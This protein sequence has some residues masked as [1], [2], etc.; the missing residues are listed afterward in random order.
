MLDISD[1]LWEGLFPSFCFSEWQIVF[2]CFLCML[3]CLRN[4]GIDLCFLGPGLVLLR[5]WVPGSQGWGSLYHPATASCVRK[6]LV[7]SVQDSFLLFSK[8]RDDFPFPFLHFLQPQWILYSI[9]RHRICCPLPCGLTLL[10]LKGEG[11]LVSF[12]KGCCSPPPGLQ[13]LGRLSPTSSCS[14]SDL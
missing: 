9:L 11:T 8:G 2:D 10:R 6:H 13:H 4:K 1:T 12:P 7:D 5:S 3:A 14:H